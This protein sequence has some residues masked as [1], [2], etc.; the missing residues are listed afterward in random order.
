MAI[1]VAAADILLKII[2]FGH[3]AKDLIQET[4]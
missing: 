2:A 1:R 3:V 4:Q